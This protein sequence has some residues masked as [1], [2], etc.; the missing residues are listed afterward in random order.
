MLKLVN[1]QKLRDSVYKMGK[2]LENLAASCSICCKI[3]KVYM[4]IFLGTFGKMKY[5]LCSKVNMTWRLW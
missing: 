3:L 2:H 1:Q 4:G 5:V